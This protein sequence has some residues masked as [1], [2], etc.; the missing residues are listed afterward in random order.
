MPLI[1]KNVNGTL[2]NNDEKFCFEK[3]LYLSMILRRKK[4][5]QYKSKIVHFKSQY[6]SF[7]SFFI[8]IYK[9]LKK[10]QQKLK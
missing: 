8:T 10:K 2:S 5:K 9:F 7:I 6:S 1:I 4:I 3:Y